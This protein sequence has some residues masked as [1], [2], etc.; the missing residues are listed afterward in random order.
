MN[1]PIYLHESDAA[2]L[3]HRVDSLAHDTHSRRALA[4]LR[5]ELARALILPA[6]SF[7]SDVVRIGSS[8]EVHDLTDDETSRYVLCYPEHAEISSGRLS[9]FAPLGTAILGIPAGHSFTWD[10]PGGTRRLRILG[11]TSPTASATPA[12]LATH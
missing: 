1:P 3:R 4:G 11:V 8:V 5:A 9:V 12:I 6:E 2:S 10:M 7:P